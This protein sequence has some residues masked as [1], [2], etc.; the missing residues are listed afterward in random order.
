MVGGQLSQDLNSSLS[1]SGSLG[2]FLATAPLVLGAE[3]CDE[4]QVLFIMDVSWVG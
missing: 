2:S 4:R 1:D 3:A